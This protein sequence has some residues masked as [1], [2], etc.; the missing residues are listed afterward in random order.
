MG[1]EDPPPDRRT[2]LKLA[3]CG[4]GGAVG[5]AVALP[6]LSVLVHPARSQ[7]VTTPK[8]PIDVGDLGLL[9]SDWR[10]VDVI[11]PEVRD[12]WTTQQN[13]VLGA[14]WIRKGK[15]DKPEALSAACP[16]LGCP[17]G[18]EPA[19]Q[20]FLCPCHNSYFKDNGD[21]SDGPAKRGLDPLPI[22]VKEG[23]LRLT[24]VAYKLDTKK[25]EPA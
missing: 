22:E 12:A 23:R 13:V 9:G 3:T 19:K 8:D 11:A 2:F 14:A 25:R 20:Q 24:W 6:T 5:A 1:D 7:T 17:V 18:W 10:K 15:G 4:I 21:V 16:H